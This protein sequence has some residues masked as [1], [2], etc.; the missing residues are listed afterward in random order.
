[1]IYLSVI[2]IAM[3]WLVSVFSFARWRV[4]HRYAKGHHGNVLNDTI[5]QL[6]MKLS[7]SV[8]LVWI[9]L[10]LTHTP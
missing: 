2:F 7:G 10:M 8:V 5:F 4:A 3:V 1:M 6:F 9:A